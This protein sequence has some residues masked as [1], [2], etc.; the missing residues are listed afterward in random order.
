MIAGG[1]IKGCA[2]AGMEVGFYTCLKALE[3]EPD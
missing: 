2:A 3:D 1:R